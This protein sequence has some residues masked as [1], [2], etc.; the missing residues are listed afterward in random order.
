M[1]VLENIELKKS[2]RIK[3]LLFHPPEDRTDKMLLELMSFT[4]VKYKT[5]I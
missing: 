4:R 1:D 3:E 5:I 2:E